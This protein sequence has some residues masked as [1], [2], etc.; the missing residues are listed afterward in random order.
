MDENLTNKALEGS[1]ENILFDDMEENRYKLYIVSYDAV[2]SGTETGITRKEHYNLFVFSEKED[3]MKYMRA[4]N[5]LIITP[6]LAT[7]KFKKILEETSDTMLPEPE[8]SNTVYKICTKLLGNGDGKK[9]Q[10]RFY[11]FKVEE[12][13]SKLDI[14]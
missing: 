12:V 5:R 8:G 11:S 1:I 9:N 14:I 3:A 6:F 4:A 10:S 2:F 13:N 7:G